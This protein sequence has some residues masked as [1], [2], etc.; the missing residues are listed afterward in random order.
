MRRNKKRNRPDCVTEDEVEKYTKIYIQ[1]RL[2]HNNYTIRSNRFFDKLIK[3]TKQYHLLLG[4][5]GTGKSAF[6]LNGY[7]YFLLKILKKGYTIYYF[8]LR[9]SNTLEKVSTVKNKKTQ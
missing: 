5:T 2:K 1:A 6:L 9:N 7:F 4:D 8:T 3:T